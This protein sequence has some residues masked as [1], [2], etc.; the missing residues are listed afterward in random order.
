MLNQ[1]F[2]SKSLQN[3]RKILRKKHRQPV[4]NESLGIRGIGKSNLHPQNLLTGTSKIAG[5]ST[6]R[7]AP[8]VITSYSPCSSAKN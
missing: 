4:Y 5:N 2:R 1:A 6:V 8:S 3:Y 7:I